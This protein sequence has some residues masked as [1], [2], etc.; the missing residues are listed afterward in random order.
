[1]PINTDTLLKWVDEIRKEMGSQDRRITRLET[2][3]KVVWALVG[4]LVAVGAIIAT[5]HFKSL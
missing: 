1:M 3:N 2:I 5:I 4:L